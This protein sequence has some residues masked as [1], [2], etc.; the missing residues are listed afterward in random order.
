MV[1]AAALVQ[2]GGGGGSKSCPGAID[3]TGSWRGPATNDAQARGVPGTITANI[4]QGGCSLGGIW[5][6]AFPASELN[7]AL[8]ITGDP[9]TSASVAL[10]L[11]ESTTDCD[12]TGN[13]CQKVVGCQYDVV[14]T[15]VTPN[16]IVGT[17]ATGSNCSQSDTGDFDI[18]R[19]GPAPAPATPTPTP[20]S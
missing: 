18:R 8:L 19:E 17:Y 11:G 15:L 20:P 2:C 4:S 13:F 16:E 5:N 7:R 3:I 1:L 14:G 12:E 6:W 10:V 9:P